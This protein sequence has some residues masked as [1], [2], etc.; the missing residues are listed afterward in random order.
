MFGPVMGR[1]TGQAAGYT[2]DQILPPLQLKRCAF[3][4]A[5]GDWTFAGADE[6]VDTDRGGNCDR[7]DDHE[8]QEYVTQGFCDLHQCLQPGRQPSMSNQELVPGSDAR[9]AD[10][11]TK[12]IPG[13][14]SRVANAESTLGHSRRILRTQIHRSCAAQA[15]HR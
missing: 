11:L 15:L 1:M 7:G 9:V 12:A 5:F 10:L 13:A 3:V 4:C 6:R 14:V 2:V 8:R